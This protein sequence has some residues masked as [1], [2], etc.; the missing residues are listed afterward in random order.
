MCHR[1]AVQRN[2]KPISIGRDTV[3]GPAFQGN[4]V[5]GALRLLFI[6]KI[7]MRRVFVI[8]KFENRRNDNAVRRCLSDKTKWFYQIIAER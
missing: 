6:M 5:L 8:F 7:I 3:Q 2:K 1:V 4:G